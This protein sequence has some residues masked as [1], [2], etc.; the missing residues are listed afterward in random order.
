[1]AGLG[2]PKGTLEKEQDQEDPRDSK[3]HWGLFMNT[4][5]V[6]GLLPVWLLAGLSVSPSVLLS[7]F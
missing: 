3:R 2:E 4:S 6:T 7:G 5:L 1:M